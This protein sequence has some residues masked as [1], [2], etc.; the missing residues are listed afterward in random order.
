MSQTDAARGL[1]MSFQQI[2]KYETGAN[3]ISASRLYE[4]AVLFGVPVSAFFEGLAHQPGGL[5]LD[6]ATAQIAREL[7]RIED[8]KKKHRILSLVRE[9]ARDETRND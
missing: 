7:N 6:E 1:D 4:I 5:P 8:S 2:Q 9:I 3:R